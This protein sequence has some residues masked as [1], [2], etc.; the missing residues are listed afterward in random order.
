MA[1]KRNKFSRGGRPGS[2]EKGADQSKMGHR[3]TYN[4]GDSNVMKA[5]KK[6]EDTFKKG[7]KVM[8]HKSKARMD[9]YARG[10]RSGGSP[11]SSAKIKENTASHK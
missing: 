3:T 10:G 1:G 2:G 4:A 8:G 7:G 11:F 9:K 5:A 6:T